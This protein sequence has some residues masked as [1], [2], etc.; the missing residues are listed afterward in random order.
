LR[1]RGAF[2]TVGDSMLTFRLLPC[3]LL[4]V[5]LGASAPALRAAEPFS[6]AFADKLV[7]VKNGALVPAPGNRLK[8]AKYVAFYYAASWCAPC[9]EFTP[10]LLSAYKAIKA[11]HPEFEL[12]YVSDDKTPEAMT[13][14]MAK[15]GMVWPAVRFD[16]RPAL[17]PLKRPAHEVGIP[18]LVFLDAKGRDLS[19]TFKPDG[20]YVGPQEVLADI[21][22]H[23]RM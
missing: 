16:A 1:G 21:K 8:G 9:R 23:F 3:A 12:I 4:A 17:P 5:F 22:R 10:E 14:Y 2:S 6:S 7:S 19:A 18:N 13:H 15:A 20:E 11:R